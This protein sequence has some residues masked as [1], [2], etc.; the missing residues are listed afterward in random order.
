VIAWG[1]VRTTHDL[2]LVVDAVERARLTASLVDA[3]F[4]VLNDVQGFTNLLHR[5][6]ELGHLDLLWVEGTT[7]ERL[8]ARTAEMTGPDG[9]PIR[10]LSPEHLVAMKVRAIQNRATRVLR[11][12]PDIHYL[13]ALPGIDENEV[14]GYFEKAGL[15]E[16]YTRLKAG[17]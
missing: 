4:E 9:L 3:G 14:R 12:G 15:A 10:V 7:S 16:L 5:D 6:R 8:F 2:D 1:S 13:L 11:D 17:R